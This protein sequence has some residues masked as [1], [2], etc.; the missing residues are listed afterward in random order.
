MPNVAIVLLNWNQPDL[1]IATIKSLQNISHNSYNYKIVVVDNGSTN[2]NILIIKKFINS[3]KTR[4][5]ARQVEN[6]E[7]ITNQTNL[8]YAAGN[9]V[10]IDYAINNDFDYVLIANN[11]IR[12]DPGFLEILIHKIK[13]NPKSIIAPKIYFEKGC[14]FHHDRYQPHELGRVIWALGGNIDW[15]NIYGT[16]NGIDI[17]D[18][19]QLDSKFTKPDFVSGC[20]FLT[21]ISLF[22]DI[23]K[24]DENYYLYMEDVD[25]SLRA[26]RANYSLIV[27]PK[28]VI[29]HI[30]SGTAIASSNIQD[31]FITRNRLLFA[32]K[33]A[34]FRSRFALF[35]E[36]IKILFQGRIW[37]KIA[38]KDYY[39][40]N[41]G[42]GSWV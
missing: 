5:P 27:N 14:E 11:D 33:F 19:G 42:K 37:Q 10:G 7:L 40:S 21:P 25:L 12:V 36:S 6:C 4:L 13:Q 35:R 24:F 30:N 20:C 17:V 15:S 28:S 1:T 29:W 32:H 16:N 2:K 8:G 34:S 38:V 41:L 3:L 23:G 26:K 18:H 39:L 31:Y 22:K 9:N